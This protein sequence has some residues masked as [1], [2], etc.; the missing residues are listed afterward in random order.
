MAD[1]VRVNYGKLLRRILLYFVVVFICLFILYPYFVMVCTALKS[2]AEIFAMEGTIFPK[3]V[4]WSNFVDIW[5]RGPL[6]LLGT[7]MLG[8]SSE[9][10]AS[11]D[12]KAHH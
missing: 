7:W 2:R 4:M 3:M 10:K 11:V 5:Q 1:N 12:Q 8:W 6:A 9:K